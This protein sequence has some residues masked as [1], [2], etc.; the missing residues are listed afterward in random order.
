MH[1]RV[2]E[3]TESIGETLLTPHINYTRPVLALLA[4]KIKIKGIAHISG[5]GV[6]EN[7]PRILPEGCAVEIDRAA[8]P[9]LPIFKL[10]QKVGQLPDSEAY[11]T[12]NMGIGL[13]MIVSPDVVAE[14]RSLLKEYPLYEIGRVLSGKREVRLL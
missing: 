4:E 8:C 10:L 11:R 14:M 7:I 12:F 9:V 3:L 2:P 6:L 5:G 13:V 1:T